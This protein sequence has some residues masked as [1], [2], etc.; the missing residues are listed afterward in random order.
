MLVLTNRKKKQSFFSLFSSIY[1]FINNAVEK[2]VPLS[3]KSP[4]K[5]LIIVLYHYN[6]KMEIVSYFRFLP[7]NIPHTPKCYL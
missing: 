6:E 5:V 1:L 4:A 3:F 7:I 2:K